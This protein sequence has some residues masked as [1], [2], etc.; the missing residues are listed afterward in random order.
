[1]E[2]STMNINGKAKCAYESTEECAAME[3]C[4]QCER[5]K[6][7]VSRLAAYEGTGLT[8][9]EISTTREPIS[10]C[11]GLICALRAAEEEISTLE[12]DLSDAHMYNIELR[13]G[14]SHLTAQ[15][16][17]FQR[18]LR[19]DGDCFYCTGTG[20]K[21]PGGQHKPCACINGSGWQFDYKR[22]VGGER[23]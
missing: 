19:K 18:V 17:V 13:E 4:Y 20:C 15:V 22:F 14:I 3:S 5:Y 21:T 12:S 10:T 16:E 9:E 2:R 1:M 23:E 7:M 6:M 8:P 11:L